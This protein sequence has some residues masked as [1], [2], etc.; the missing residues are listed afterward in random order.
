M[1]CSIQQIH[2]GNYTS[3]LFLYYF[4]FRRKDYTFYWQSDKQPCP[5]L[6]KTNFNSVKHVLIDSKRVTNNS[7]NYF[8]NTTELTLTNTYAA[9]EDSLPQTLNCIVPL[10]NLTKLIIQCY[11]FPLEQII[12]L[13]RYTSNLHTL[14]FNLLCAK[15]IK[16]KVIQQSP[17]FQYVSNTNK[18]KYLDLHDDC[19]LERIQLI[20]KLFPKLEYMKIGMK[21]KE[22][23]EIV[24]FILS[25]N[26]IQTGYLTVLCLSRAPKRCLKEINMLIKLENLVGDYC[27]KFVNRDLYLWW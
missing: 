2:I 25:N 10:K 12:N 24:R 20:V 21:K 16:T 1:E 18:I 5:Y 11:Y 27:I 26:T 23:N 13:I 22:T 8:P 14:K 7:V 9:F 3:N 6:R 4:F 15:K 19:P 17:I